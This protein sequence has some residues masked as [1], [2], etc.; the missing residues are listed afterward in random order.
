MT[1]VVYVANT[2]LVEVRG[3]KNSVEAAFIGNASVTLTV[4]DAADAEIGGQ[5]WPAAL[6]FVAGSDGLYRGT[7]NSAAEL[8]AGKTYCAH[9]DADAG[10]GLSGHWEYVFVPKI[11]RGV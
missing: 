4:K 3:L 7:L 6:D 2:N 5:T 1:S 8:V 9:I 10:G 11:R